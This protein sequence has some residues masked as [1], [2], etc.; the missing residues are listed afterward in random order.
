MIIEYKRYVHMNIIDTQTTILSPNS[1]NIFFFLFLGAVEDNSNPVPLWQKMTWTELSPQSHTIMWPSLLLDTLCGLQVLL[2]VFNYLTIFS[3]QR[4]FTW[5]EK[6]FMNE[7]HGTRWREF[8]KCWFTFSF[9]TRPFISNRSW[10]FPIR[11][12]QLN[13]VRRNTKKKPLYC[14]WDPSDRI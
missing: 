2:D 5:V 14:Y 3:K 8:H 7:F 13:L 1:S 10:I 12:N 6:V 9:R 11:V 4:P